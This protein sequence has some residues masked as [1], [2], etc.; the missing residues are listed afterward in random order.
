MDF[1]ESVRELTLAKLAVSRLFAVS[2]L[3]ATVAPA[4]AQQV[5]GTLDQADATT[6]V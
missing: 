6:T 4:S 1:T 5:T 3:A 2:L